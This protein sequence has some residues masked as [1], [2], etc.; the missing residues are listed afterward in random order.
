VKGANCL[1]GQLELFKFGG[2]IAIDMIVGGGKCSF[3][4]I[5]FIDFVN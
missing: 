5:K 2:Y 3:P 4:K 1:R